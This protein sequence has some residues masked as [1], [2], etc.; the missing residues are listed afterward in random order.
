MNDQLFELVEEKDLLNPLK[1]EL[2]EIKKIFMKHVFQKIFL[3]IWQ[4]IMI[5]LNGLN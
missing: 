4:N 1:T 5:V 3:I 2:K